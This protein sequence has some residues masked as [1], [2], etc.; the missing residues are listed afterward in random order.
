MRYYYAVSDLLLDYLSANGGPTGEQGWGGDT[1]FNSKFSLPLSYPKIRK[2]KVQCAV[3][4]G[5]NG[6][7]FFL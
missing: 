6:L 7:L 1:I 5:Q 3:Q 4:S 2:K